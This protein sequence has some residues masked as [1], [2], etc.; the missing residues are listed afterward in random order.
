MTRAE[1]IE[2][3]RRS[4]REDADPASS[5]HL[6]GYWEASDAGCYPEDMRRIDCRVYFLLVA[7]ALD[8][9]C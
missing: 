8:D 2:E 6:F 4:A 5:V 3:L 1:I 7:H 9:E